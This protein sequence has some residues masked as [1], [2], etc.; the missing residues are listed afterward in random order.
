ML[1]HVFGF[2][3]LIAYLV[4]VYFGKEYIKLSIYFMFKIRMFY[5]VCNVGGSRVKKQQKMEQKERNCK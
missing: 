5:K 4:L 2:C 3:L 1:A